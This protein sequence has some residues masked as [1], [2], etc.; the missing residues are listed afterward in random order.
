MKK[1]L[2]NL[3]QSYDFETETEF[4]D[5]IIDSFYNG[6]GQ[7]RSLFLEMNKE[8]QRKFVSYLKDIDFEYMYKFTK[9]V[10][11]GV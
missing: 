2:I 5:Y 1:K 6:N 8:N 11:I 3:A 10:I 4:F 9:Q 7:A